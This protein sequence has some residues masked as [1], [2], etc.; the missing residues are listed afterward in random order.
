M[1]WGGD[2]M[3]EKPYYSVRTGKNPLT[4][5][6]DLPTLLRLFRPIYEHFDGEGYFQED[7]GYDCV[8]EGFV[9]GSL[10]HDLEG[11][12]LLDLRKTNLHPVREHLSDYKEDDLF[13]IIEF[14]YDH[15]SKPTKRFYHEFSGC[16][17]HCTEFDRPQ[18]RAEYR[19]RVNRVLKVYNEG[20]ELSLDG[21][22]LSLP[23]TGL[24]ALL[25][26]PVP[27]VD[28]ENIDARIE[29]ARRKFRRFRSSLDERRDAIR[30]LADVLEYLRPKI[31]NVLTTKDEGDIFNL[32]N[33]FGI[34]HHNELQ[35]SQ[36]DKAIWYSWLFY[37]YLATIHAVLRLIAKGNESA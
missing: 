22:I 5:S 37:Y 12:L 11:I 8:D 29:A 16:G 30:D 31:K 15:C 6:I 36:Y 24:E 32:A 26:A 33:N 13:D 14:L 9:P 7:L 20:Y 17:W 23:E 25:E 34:R 18:G 27:F 3:R 10:G 1:S 28:P 4:G 35:K 21:E 2:I 19:E